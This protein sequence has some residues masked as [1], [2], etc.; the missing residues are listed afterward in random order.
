MIENTL[1]EEKEPSWLDKVIKTLKIEKSDNWTNEFGE[2]ISSILP[3]QKISTLSLFTGGGGLDI[4]FSDVGFDIKECVEIDSRFVETLKENNKNC[5]NDSTKI[6]CIDIREYYPKFKNIDFIIGGPP[7]QTFSAAGAR[8]AG[9]KAL[10]DKRGTLFKEYVR[11]VD[12]LQ[13]K[14]FLFENVY[15]IIG[16]QNGEP[17]RLIQE[18][19]RDIGYKVHWRILDAADY[20]VPQHRERLIIVGTKE[21]EFRFPFPTHGPDSKSN[22]FYYTSSQALEGLNEQIE[23]KDFTG[24][25]GHLLKDIPPGLNYS[26]YTEKMGHPNPIFGWR[27]KFSDYLYKADPDRPVRTI[28]AQGG[29]YTGPLSWENRAFTIKEFKRLQTFPDSY[30][31]KGNRQVQIM[32]IGNSVPPQL[33]RILALSVLEQIFNI[34]LP[35]DINYMEKEFVLGFRKRKMKLTKDYANKAKEAITSQL[36]D[37]RIIITNSIIISGTKKQ[38]INNNY[39]LLDEKTNDSME[40]IIKYDLNNES[41]DFTLDEKQS[42]DEDQYSIVIKLSEVHQSLL[43]TKK[44]S[45]ISKS[46]NKKSLL[47]LWK[48][49]EKKIKKHA[50]KDDLI[51][52]FGYYK[53]QKD[54]NFTFN[55][56]NQNISNINFWNIVSEITR[57]TAIG[58]EISAIEISSLLH[59]NE[60]SFKEYAK[61][62][63]SMGFEI[64]NNNTNSQ[65]KENYFLIP[66][67]FPTLNER[68]LQRFTN[69]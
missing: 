68:S 11:L 35:F 59:T 53:S 18:A 26:Y 49:L 41:W 25:H 63:K 6:S 51:Q 5:K 10:S 30:N 17:W 36:L 54:M 32:Q 69:L 47:T 3:K 44:I 28:K 67:R 29:Q 2:K 38:Y 4:A 22:K 7:C 19:F 39:I 60:I 15:R 23:T 40:Y 45:L 12:L 31:I 55:L 56:L 50:H 27:S 42:L 48:F 57:G 14:G 43:K 37:G 64:R 61:E 16:A 34:E 24:R 20:G 66:Y 46:S 13:P 8:V 1:F 58:E 62:L 9:V 33:G 21:E 65:L 52:L